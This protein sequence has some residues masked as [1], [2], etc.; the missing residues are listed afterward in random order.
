MKS[1]GVFAFG[2]CAFLTTALLAQSGAEPGER[3]PPGGAEG[4]RGGRMEF[5]SGR[6]LGA[7]LAGIADAD[8]NGEVSAVE[9][10]GLMTA[11]TAIPSAEAG[12]TA[13]AVIDTATLKQMLF[14]NAIDR[15]KD[16]VLEVSDLQSAFAELDRNGDGAIAN[17]EMTAGRRN[18]E[19]REPGGE[20]GNAPPAPGGNAPPA[21]GAPPATPPEGGAPA[22]RRPQLSRI[23]TTAMT[24]LVRV[25]D[26]DASGSVSVEEWKSFLDMQKADAKGAIGGEQVTALMKGIESTTAPAGEG[27]RRPAGLG[28]MIDGMLKGENGKALGPDDLNKIF[29]DMDKNAD[30]TLQKDEITPPRRGRA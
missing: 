1:T 4:G 2:A 14:V 25:A 7:L 11:I 18:R 20:G 16:H 13:T 10:T 22:E 19:P 9:W 21:G 8:S 5:S 24:S 27:E 26:K 15:D 29:S 23:Q 3:R 12:S 17:D 28:G 30:K 6:A